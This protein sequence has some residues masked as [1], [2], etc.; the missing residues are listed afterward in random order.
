VRMRF[1]VIASGKKEPQSS[2][3]TPRRKTG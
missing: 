2:Q 3:R 1:P